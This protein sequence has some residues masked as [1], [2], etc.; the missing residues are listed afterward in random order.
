MKNILLLLILLLLVPLVI[1]AGDVYV[2][3]YY[4]SN[5]TYVQP[6]YRSAPDGNPYNN[7]SFPGNASVFG[8]L[9]SVM[10]FASGN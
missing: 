7:Y 8:I 10:I 2:K 3:G 9:L 5:G 4:R 6:H 1:F